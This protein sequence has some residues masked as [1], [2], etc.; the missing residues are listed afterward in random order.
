MGKIIEFLVRTDVWLG[1]IVV[2]L[3]PVLSALLFHK[4][5]ELRRQTNMRP[6][7]H[8]IPSSI[9]LSEKLTS[10]VKSIKAIVG[11]SSDIIFRQFKLG[12]DNRSCSIVHIDGLVDTQQL[13]QAILHPLLHGKQTKTKLNLFKSQSIKDYLLNHTI[14]VSDIKVTKEIDKVVR[15]LLS[16]SVLLLVDGLDE[17]L[18][19]SV[20]KWVSRSV[21]EPISESLVRGPRMGFIENLRDNTA[22]LRRMTTDPNLTFKDFDVGERTKKQLTIAYIR[23]IANEELLTEVTRRIE[24][25][26][27]D[28]V[29]ESGYIEQL[30]ED[31]YFSIFPQVQSTERPDRVMAAILEGRVAIM[32]D[33]TPYV[34]IAPATFSIMLQSPEDYYERWIPMSL[35]R[36]LRYVAALLSVFLP[37]FYI[38]F[39]SF[40]QGLIPT[41]L[42]LAIA[43]TR[44]GVP[45]PTIIEALLMEVSI[46]LLREAGLRLPKP[47]GQTVGLVGALIIGEAAVQAGLVSPI[48]V[49]VVSATAI[50][51][52]VSP[53]YNAGIALRSLRFLSMFSAALLGLYGISLFFVALCIHA[54]KLKSFGLPYV[55]PGTLYSK[56]DWKDFFLRL[57]LFTMRKRP[58]EYFPKDQVRMRKK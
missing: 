21:E 11:D 19:L 45:F 41:D 52:F 40:H 13:Q 57:P 35:I 38:A 42:A 15:Q 44:V 17:A 37:S 1:T 39:V 51:S 34:L 46:E 30:I 24:D 43:G 22:I 14:E 12:N 5:K 25:L 47:V 54:V 56:E 58:A 16:G 33:G 8:F 6:K 7:Q 49:I 36:V 23:D 32:L 55:T 9:V 4:L 10:N 48:M 53:Q 28:H 31:N 29:A 18:L 26:D 27:I 20:K 50:S 2:V 3:V